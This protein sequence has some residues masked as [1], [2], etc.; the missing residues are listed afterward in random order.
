[1]EDFWGIFEDFK[2]QDIEDQ[3]GQWFKKKF[4]NF[5][6]DVLFTDPEYKDQLVRVSYPEMEL[7][8]VY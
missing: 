7:M 1:M 6:K 3:K 8:T 2:N 4:P 5:G